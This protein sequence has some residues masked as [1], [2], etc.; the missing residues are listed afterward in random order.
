MK[1][2]SNVD[3]KWPHGN[4]CSFVKELLKKDKVPAT[5]GAFL[6]KPTTLV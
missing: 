3:R 4:N 5:A 6:K 1:P 2:N